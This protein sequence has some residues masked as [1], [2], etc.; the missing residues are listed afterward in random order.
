M[1]L[2]YKLIAF[3]LASILPVITVILIFRSSASDILVE[4]N[5]QYSVS[6]ALNKA[7]SIDRLFG[8]TEKAL[9]N[10]CTNQKTRD[11]LQSVNDKNFY[12]EDKYRLTSVI[13]EKLDTFMNLYPVFDGIYIMPKKGGV[14]I[15]KGVLNL[16]YSDL[17]NPIY[18]NSVSNPEKIVWTLSPNGDKKLKLT[19]S[20]GIINLYNDEVLRIGYRFD[21]ENFSRVF[22]YT[23]IPGMSSYLSPMGL[24]KSFI[25]TIHQKWASEIGKH[26]LSAAR[27]KTA[28]EYLNLKLIM[29]LI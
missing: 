17:S 1:S 15:Y 3:I 29:I 18:V 22:L 8:D 10:I 9:L 28:E 26:L 5:T 19:I 2:K 14:P 21:V 7:E 27:D 4:K 24:S 16:A 11:Y 13:E 12:E 23:V 6:M 25:R 20:K